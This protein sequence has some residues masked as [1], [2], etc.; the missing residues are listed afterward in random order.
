MERKDVQFSAKIQ[1][2]EKIN[3]E[4]LKCKVYVCALGK[5][6]NLSYISRNAADEALYS[7]YNI[8]VIGHMYEDDRGGLHMGGHDMEVVKD[9]EGKYHLKSLTVPFGVVPAQDNVHYE[10][11]REANGNVNSYVVAEC[12]LWTGRYPE[13]A[14]A[15]YSQNW[16]FNQSMEI[17]VADYVPLEEDKKYTDILHYTYSAL[18]LLGKSDEPDYNTEPCF[19]EAHLEIAYNLESNEKFMALMDELRKSLSE[20]FSS[21]S[22]GKE[23]RVK[24]TNEI[25][26]AILTE[27]NVN[28]ESLDFEIADDMTEESFREM[29]SDFNLRQ[30]KA[31][32]THTKDSADDETDS[33]AFANDESDN[34]E[35]ATAYTFTYLEKAEV[36]SKAMPN[37]ETARYWVCDFD[38]KYAYVEKCSYHEEPGGWDCQKGRFEYSF[39][40]SEKVASVTG[41]FEEMLVCWLTPKEKA[42]IESMRGEYEALTDYR[43]QREKADREHALDEAV[44]QF[45][46]LAGNEEFDAIAENKYSYESVEALQNACYIVRGKLG[47]MPKARRLAAEPSVPI[48]ISHETA[49]LREKLHEAYGRR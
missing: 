29:V 32:N 6:R 37:T 14:E 27:F 16:L 34:S 39:D 46:D 13:L 7:L 25:R 30:N 20:V 1:P 41:E 4:F 24:M 17:N 2:V 12:I 43:A 18:C 49:T 35:V 23:E 40:E 8:P 28:L 22:E 15:V 9:A 33:D 11:I 44:G 36:L 5:N 47:V 10:D 42:A 21:K 19:P 38:D 26:D 48:G 31:N 45:A 3:N